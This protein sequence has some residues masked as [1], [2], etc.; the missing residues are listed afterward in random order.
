ML[1]F[2]SYQKVTNKT[3]IYHQSTQQFIFANKPDGSRS[4]S[5]LLSLFYCVTKLTGEAGEVAQL[6]GKLIRDHDGVVTSEFINKMKM[7]LGDVLWYVAQ[8]AEWC[9][10][11]LDEVGEANIQKLQSRKDRGKLRGSGDNR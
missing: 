3:A 11:P 9:D 8:L 5:D 6:A 10:I 1:T 2:N 7:E 4:A